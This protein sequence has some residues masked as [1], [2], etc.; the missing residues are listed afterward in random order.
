MKKK[1]T[2]TDNRIKRRIS[3]VM[4]GVIAFTTVG[5][6]LFF[7]E[8]KVQ[9]KETL[10]GIEKVISNL[11]SSKSSYDI[12]EIVPDDVIGTL[13]VNDVSG[14][15]IDISISQK[16]GFL[17]YYVGG[18]EP[19]R[20]D[21]ERVV[22]GI[23]TV[24]GNEV[25][26]NTTLNE[27]TL[28]YGVVKGITDKVKNSDIY[29]EEDGPFAF[30]EDYK[31]VRS[32][33]D[34]SKISWIQNAENF[35]KYKNNKKLRPIIRTLSDSNIPDKDY[36]DVAR[37]YMDPV[38]IL[39][40]YANYVGWFEG[41]D[42]ENN[43]ALLFVKSYLEAKN[44][45]PDIVSYEDDNFKLDDITD[46]S[47]GSFEP[48][49]VL[50]KSAGTTAEETV[51]ANITA[52]FDAVM[53]EEGKKLDVRSGYS[54]YNY[55]ALSEIT[56]EIPGETPVYAWDEGKEVF[57]YVGLYSEI[58]SA[59]SNDNVSPDG[60]EGKGDSLESYES[61]TEAI[62][63][64]E[65]YA[66]PTVDDVNVE[67]IVE[68]G[69][70]AE[71]VSKSDNSNE[72][73]EGQLKDDSISPDR[74]KDDIKDNLT[75]TQ[76][77]EENV[78]SDDAV[79]GEDELI[80]EE[81]EVYLDGAENNEYYIVTFEYTD[82]D[83]PERTSVNSD[84][85]LY[86]IRSFKSAEESSGAQYVLASTDDPYG[87]IVPNRMG[88]GLISVKDE[89]NK[90]DFLFE[91]AKGEGNFRWLSDEAN[92]EAYRI[93]GDEIYY[94]FDI[95][96]KEWFKRFVFDRDCYPYDKVDESSDTAKKLTLNVVSMKASEVTEY[97]IGSKE[98]DEYVY[99]LIALMSGD[100]SYCIGSKEKGEHTFTNYSAGIEN[101]I[102]PYVYTRIINRVAK[103]ETPVILDYK[104]IEDE[105]KLE[106][107]DPAK[108]SLAYNIV[109]A[110]MLSE[111]EGYNTL[112]YGMEHDF[113]SGAMT[114]TR[115]SPF[116][117]ADNNGLNFISNN[118]N[119]FVNKHV[120]VYNRRNND[121][122]TVR[123]NPANTTFD[124]KFNE[125][126]INAGFLDVVSDILSEK[127]YRDADFSLKDKP[128]KHDW[129]S[130][131][132]VIRYIIG[133]G[134]SRKTEGKEE[135]RILEIDPVN[136]VTCHDLYADNRD[137]KNDSTFL[138]N[139]PKDSDSYKK[140][141]TETENGDQ[142]IY[143]GELYYKDE[144][145]NKKSLLKQE[146]LHI[147]ITYMTTAEY[148]GHI[149]DINAEYDL[150]YIGMNTGATNTSGTYVV[151]KDGGYVITRARGDVSRDEFLSYF[152]NVP[153]RGRNWQRWEANYE[154][155]RENNKYKYEGWA[156]YNR[157]GDLYDPSKAVRYELRI[158]ELRSEIGHYEN[159]GGY[160][161][162]LSDATDVKNG[163]AS[164]VD[165]LITDFNDINMDGLVYSNVGDMAYISDTAGGALKLRTGGSD[166]EP[167]Y[168]WLETVDGKQDGYGK[169]WDYMSINYSPDLGYSSNGADNYSLY[170]TRYNGND[171]TKEKCEALK[172][173]A[174]A[175]YP[176][177]LADDFFSVYDPE[178][179]KGT[180][181]ECTVDNSSYMYEAT[182]WLIDNYSDKNVFRLS[183][184]PANVFDW[185]VLSLGKPTIEMTD[186][187]SK[188]SQS[189]TVYLGEADKSGDGHYY[190]YY[191]FIIDSRGSSTANAKFNVG[192]YI[193][194][195]ADGK[196]SP[197][198]EGIM[199]TD[200]K[201]LT[202]YSTVSKTGIDNNGMPIY[203]LTPGHEYEARCR[204]SGSFIGCL[205]W[206]LNVYQIG[207][208]YRRTNANGYYAVR[209][210]E[211]HVEVLQLMQSSTANNWN[212]QTE[213]ETANSQFHRL[214]NDTE[215]VPFT[216]NITS[217][218]KNK[219]VEEANPKTAEGYY[220]YFKKYNMLVL[221]YNDIYDSMTGEEGEEIAK[222]IK[223]YIDEGYSVLFTH[224]CTSF[225][226]NKKNQ[227]KK[228][229]GT[230]LNMLGDFWGYQFN[231]VIRNIVGMD[232][233]DV[234]KESK[235]ENEKPYKPRSNRSIVLD[236]EAHGF[237]YH[238]INHWGYQ[239]TSSIATDKQWTQSMIYTDNKNANYDEYNRNNNSRNAHFNSS[240]GYSN[241]YNA[242]L[243]GGQY[244]Q[245]TRV[246][247][248]NKGQI[249]QYPYKLNTDFPVAQTHSQYYQLDMTA[250]DDH[251][252][253]SD[254]VV[255]YCISDI[256]GVDVNTYNVSPNDVRNT[257]YIYNKGNVTYSGVGHRQ[258]TGE[259]EMRLFI[260]TMIAAYRSG[261]HAPDLAI[262][263]SFDTNAKKARNLYVSY[264]DQI[265]KIV[266]ANAA[267]PDLA[268]LNKN[269]DID[270]Y[271]DLY[272]NAD[273]VS[274]VQ[275][276]S[277]IDHHL[278]AKVFYEDDGSDE[279][280]EFKA[281]P[282]GDYYYDSASGKFIAGAYVRR[283][284]GGYREPRDDEKPNYAKV[285]D[286]YYKCDHSRLRDFE[287]SAI[288][289]AKTK[290][291]EMVLTSD[292]TAGD[293]TTRDG[294]T[295][296]QG[297]IERE[298]GTAVTIMDATSI[299]SSFTQD[300]FSNN[301]EFEKFEKLKDHIIGCAQIENGVTYK[302]RIPVKDDDMWGGI[303]KSGSDLKNAKAVYVIVMD[304][305][306][307]R[308][309]QDG[310]DA[311]SS[312]GDTK[313]KIYKINMTKW[314][315]DKADI[316]R[317]EVFDL[318]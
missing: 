200:L 81:E 122:A 222:G 314:R 69:N 8:K 39:D 176:I 143:D 309:N 312:T 288:D 175:G 124:T 142:V 185:Y 83:D 84:L 247:Q 126:E 243:G 236:L 211:E 203:E 272:F 57:V 230:V 123:L 300:N 22:N 201:D 318:D 121:D 37:G 212:M 3:A 15:S 105:T 282:D 109:N 249:T 155:Y 261:L 161:H 213:N 32:G 210:S 151:D 311:E 43:T 101:D 304:F 164:E 130:E 191:K 270:N 258:V 317:V 77:E 156:Y 6:V 136:W 225:F 241:F 183:Y 234:M 197:T 184:T 290:V 204:L 205:P 315:A 298:D 266:S 169:A 231:T 28:R 232:R 214:L 144:A 170:R 186:E 239:S 242:S 118:Y 244:S 72:D 49:L 114:G 108:D 128:L 147:D 107:N 29:D 85:G 47:A 291:T 283:T 297:Y 192:L 198:N 76:V 226:N 250:D 134:F 206:R 159:Y 103:Y 58:T 127:M 65:A 296:I 182:K 86:Q 68:K 154:L 149:E 66:S 193:D 162:R 275:N 9:A 259:E 99:R 163:R 55:E 120:Y 264:D 34:F 90:L 316:A 279:S 276:A 278:Y 1:F 173:F 71:S 16:M 102:S 41:S 219:L 245:T 96:N 106:D 273:Q 287:E 263:D 221:G 257:Y 157:G 152:R 5:S 33:E 113:A 252:G 115:Y 253:E 26:A 145:G 60:A 307:Y 303:N 269:S 59:Q 305:A 313:G 240:L 277:A 295:V 62:E 218:T 112:I 2:G 133:S 168:T 74:D 13:S 116:D 237:T 129:V 196:F 135:L 228:R 131:A 289:T 70:E 165:K 42:D 271:V 53:D 280:L 20:D 117:F 31:E 110:L 44:N 285:G 217:I 40:E 223:K 125:G 92:G 202:E 194:I 24:S 78:L 19:I 87:I 260:N 153:Q 262:V 187:R 111:L 215:Y 195:N 93:F 177:I 95:E 67:I 17:G 23:V 80:G 97:D 64:D 188:T 284:S 274:L 100:D 27:S 256:D 208:E 18:S 14:N 35:E 306:S 148:I 267:D 255:W 48:N 91:Y 7:N 11:E 209:N 299:N 167:E 265:R 56:T 294:S 79:D 46:E 63:I 254:I 189:S 160:H 308:G 174:R 38:D 178:T 171:I 251:D 301:T 119:H 30:S 146:G 139:H 4:A 293:Y 181:N 82:N 286:T 158:S 54:V 292:P 190:A 180:I 75:D 61:T 268:G 10:Y 12:L 73:V 281:D 235:H 179:R 36:I 88:R 246:K 89:C 25:S 207:N 229:D 141:L 238:I 21:V 233:Y 98:K 248:I 45:A 310:E 166:N 137:I 150:V 52:V 94:R 140:L 224:D 132:T 138:A 227:A 199:F 302:V 216:V 172:D 104:I 51:S 50:P 220:E